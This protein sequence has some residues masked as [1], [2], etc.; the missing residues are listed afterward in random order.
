MDDGTQL[1]FE[2]LSPVALIITKIIS[3]SVEHGFAKRPNGAIRKIVRSL[4]EQIG[5]DI[6]LKNNGGTLA[7]LAFPLVGP[8]NTLTMKRP[9][10]LRNLRSSPRVCNVTKFFRLSGQLSLAP[11]P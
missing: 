5:G 7:P 4:A 8:R 3:N 9:L 6:T 1:D 2:Q 11:R 10:S